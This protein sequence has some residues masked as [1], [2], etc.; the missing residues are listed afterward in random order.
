MTQ[1][2]W[3]AIHIFYAANPQPLLVDC[4]GPLLT[5]LNEQNL[6]NRHF[7]INYWLEGPHVRLRLKPATAA[8]EPEVARQAEA[9]ITRFLQRRPAL[10]EM[11][12]GYLGELYDILF[13]LEFPQGKPAELIGPDGQMLLQKNNSFAYRAYEP[14]YGKYGG[15]AGVDL[16]EWHFAY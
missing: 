11:G 6:L 1:P 8:D 5:E 12:F 9:A 10:Y 4:V 13:D 7:F 15:P 2:D 14:E 16:A 3:L